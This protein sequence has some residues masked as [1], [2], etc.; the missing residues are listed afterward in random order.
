MKKHTAKILREYPFPDLR[1][2]GVTH[3]G[4]RTWF[5]TDDAL[6][7]FDP[8]TGKQVRRLEVPADAGTAFDG[9]QLWQIAGDKIR[10]IDPVSGAITKTIPAP[11]GGESISGM[12]WAVNALWVGNYRERRILKVDPDT[13]K[14]LKVL[15][16]DRFV[17]GVSFLDGE[18]W[19]G[20]DGDG[21]RA[22]L[23][24]VDPENGAVLERVE[25]P[26]GESV[27]GIELDRRGRIWCGGNNKVRAIARPVAQSK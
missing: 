20:A 7:A 9:Q 13:G 18:L 27:A 25:M 5:A 12:A 16:A 2:H 26:E 19:C 17:T 15:E 22:E 4:D 1:V 8:E 21:P 14:V 6:I 11:Y 3:D 24:R 10:R 23:L